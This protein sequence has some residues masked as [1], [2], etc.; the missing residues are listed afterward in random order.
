MTQCLSDTD[1]SS[2]GLPMALRVIQLGSRLQGAPTAEKEVGQA[3]EPHCPITFGVAGAMAPC[4][5]RV[6]GRGS[7]LIGEVLPYD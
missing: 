4:C 3:W 2:G 6:P 5:Q 7:L 1:G